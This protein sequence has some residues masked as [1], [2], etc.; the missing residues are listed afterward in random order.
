MIT[1]LLAFK[2]RIANVLAILATIG[3][4]EKLAAQNITESFNYT[5]NS[6]MSGYSGWSVPTGNAVVSSQY[7]HSASRSMRLVG[8]LQTEVRRVLG[9]A[10]NASVLYVDFWIRPIVYE[11]TFETGVSLDGSLVGFGKSGAQGIVY[12]SNGENW[13]DSGYRFWMNRDGC[14]A[15]D[16]VRI[17]IRQ[18]VA[19]G[20]WDL[21]VDGKMFLG[22]IAFNG[23]GDEPGYLAFLGGNLS[24]DVYVDDLKIWTSN[25]VFTDAD[26]DGMADSFESDPAHAFD[27]SSNDREQPSP[28]PNTTRIQYYLNATH[29]WFT[30]QWANSTV[31]TDQDGMPDAWELFFGLNPN[32]ASD[33]PLDADGDGVTNVQEYVLGTSPVGNYLVKDIGGIIGGYAAYGI[34][35][36]PVG[37]NNTGQVI[38]YYLDVKPSTYGYIAWSQA[39]GPVTIFR[40]TETVQ[41]RGLLGINDYGRVVGFYKP[42]TPNGAPLFW[43]DGAGLQAV[44]IPQS[45]AE[46]TSTFKGSYFYDIG[47]SYE[48]G[49]WFD[50][51][52]VFNDETNQ[53][54]YDY[55]LSA[56][57]FTVQTAESF[58]VYLTVGQTTTF[59]SSYVGISNS[60]AITGTYISD[61]TGG[62]DIGPVLGDFSSLAS[63]VRITSSG[64]YVFQTP[65]NGE[66]GQYELFPQNDWSGTVFRPLVV[67]GPGDRLGTASQYQNGTL[68]S[69]QAYV[70][71]A[72]GVKTIYEP[73]GGQILVPLKLNRNGHALLKVSGTSPAQFWLAK[74]SQFIP[75][76]YTFPSGIGFVP[77][78]VDDGDVVVGNSTGVGF[79]PAIL[80]ERGIVRIANV[81]PNGEGWKFY[82]GNIAAVSDTGL[83]VG[84]APKLGH[85]GPNRCFMMWRADDQ[86]GDGLPDDWERRIIAADTSGTYHSIWDVQPGDD[87]DGDGLTNRE[88]FLNRTDPM[89]GDNQL[90]S[91]VGLAVFAR[92]EQD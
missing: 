1:S 27:T 10:G 37:I 63:R 31:D 84:T 30:G 64:T 66:L 87:I 91:G 88:E 12:A 65:A 14:T 38:G 62:A 23:R 70:E 61:S 29:T 58:D 46:Y 36:Q 77:V 32:D 47:D 51:P 59:N 24:A 6:S 9:G 34:T 60:G 5:A 19:N 74:G 72:A 82:Q 57:P 56:V 40:N 43:W 89:T 53:Y 2:I 22:N 69:N 92:L 55:W 21:Y 39:L 15:S 11:G 79:G 71:T 35:F 20:Y 7:V 13:V 25:P 90:I 48:M 3:G 85:T 54:I 75:L 50:S 80:S 49:Q 41:P 4:C 18:D 73:S 45:I 33:G 78:G 44:D 68:T 81:A 86:D 52:V 83:I 28:E 26:N 16:W 17:S 76:N 8:G 67:N 42:L